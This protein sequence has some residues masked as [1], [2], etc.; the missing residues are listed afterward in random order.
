MPRRERGGGAAD[1]VRAPRATPSRRPGHTARRGQ[2]KGGRE[3]ILS[4]AASAAPVDEVATH[5]DPCGLVLPSTG[6]GTSPL[7]VDAHLLVARTHSAHAIDVGAE[8]PVEARDRGRPVVQSS[9]EARLLGG[10]RRLRPGHTAN[11][12]SDVQRHRHESEW[13]VRTWPSRRACPAVAATRPARDRL[14]LGGLGRRT[15]RPRS[16]RRASSRHS[17]I[18]GR[19]SVGCGAAEAY[20][21]P[22]RAPRRARLAAMKGAA[23][24]GGGVVRCG[25]G[26]DSGA[27]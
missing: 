18:A 9:Q 5:V 14:L 7:S 20:H 12:P 8:E 3:T 23:G 10:Q 13:R 27:G 25:T 17:G 26:R 24:L 16:S 11:L 2:G 1:A 21:A 6:F 22:R 4:T 15:W 19:P